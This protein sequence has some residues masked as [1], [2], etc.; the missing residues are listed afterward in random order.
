MGIGGFKVYRQLS[1]LKFLTKFIAKKLKS[2]IFTDVGSA[3]G[4]KTF[5]LLELWI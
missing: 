5:Q 3:P 2:N 4:G 1:Q